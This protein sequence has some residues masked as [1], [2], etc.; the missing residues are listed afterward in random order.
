MSQL[1]PTLKLRLD[2]YKARKQNIEAKNAL[3]KEQSEQATDLKTIITFALQQNYGK[4]GL[5]ICAF[6]SNGED[7][8]LLVNL[9]KYNQTKIFATVGFVNLHAVC[10]LETETINDTN[11]DTATLYNTQNIATKDY[12]SLLGQN[13]E[14]DLKQIYENT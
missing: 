12:C 7:N 10:I 14:C 13:E 11:K 1:S 2:A 8:A 4:T 3:F 9:E 5:D 6:N